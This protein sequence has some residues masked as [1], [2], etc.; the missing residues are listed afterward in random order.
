LLDFD[1]NCA[2]SIKKLNDKQRDALLARTVSVCNTTTR[3]TFKFKQPPI[4]KIAL[5]IRDLS[6]PIDESIEEES[7]EELKT[8]ETFPSDLS[9][10]ETDLKPPE[11]LF[12]F[13]PKLVRS[14]S[15]PIQRSAQ[16]NGRER[17]HTIGGRKTKKMRRR[18][19]KYSKTRRTRIRQTRI[20]RTRIRRTKTCRTIKQKMYRK[21]KIAHN[22]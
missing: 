15:V 3:G 11:R 10:T 20:R 19:R 21:S 14:F 2:G 12:S 5:S 18:R 8:I 4:E 17:A 22:R 16:Q 7:K 6:L 1:L 9:E 13:I